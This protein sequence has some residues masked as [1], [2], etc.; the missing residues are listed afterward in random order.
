[1]KFLFLLLLFLANA[2]F[3]DCN[4]VLVNKK[5]SSEVT[6]LKAGDKNAQDY[7]GGRKYFSISFDG[8]VNNGCI[9]YHAIE[10]W[11]G[12]NA[13]SEYVT[14]FN[15]RNGNPILKDTI[16]MGMS[17]WKE[18][19]QID[20]EIPPRI[21]NNNLILAIRLYAKGD[22]NCCPSI[23]SI[24]TFKFKN[25]HIVEIKS[26]IASSD[27]LPVSIKGMPLL[28]ARKLILERGWEPYSVID[29]DQAN[30]ANDKLL[31]LKRMGISEVEYCGYRG[32]YCGFNYRKKG[33]QCLLLM[34]DG[35]EIDD[36]KV[37]SWDFAC[38]R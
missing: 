14:F 29:K 38:E 11:N 25:I 10:G 33:E 21:E 23:P 37:D 28:D 36:M 30:V 18:Y 32:R 26:D 17:P 4:S 31:S 7:P 1:M 20:F 13:V 24:A 3:A 27:L 15:M 12:S 16:E 5:L 19:R 6:R 8:G 22:G 34:T 2:A 35:I 9:V